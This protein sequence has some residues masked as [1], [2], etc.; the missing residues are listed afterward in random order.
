MK[1]SHK[2]AA[3]I[4]ASLGL[5]VAVSAA[6]AQPGPMGGAMGPHMQG[7]MQHSAMAGVQHGARGGT[8]HGMT[9][10]PG[11]GVMGGGAAG[12]GAGQELTTPEERSAMIEKMRNAST[13]EER[14]KIAEE[15]RAEMDKRAREKGITLPAHRG[16]HF[17]GRPQAPTTN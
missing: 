11:H 16:P 12:Q 14:L 8:Q 9:G 2:F 7:G 13:P 6:Y 5:G 3:G 4:I 10:G 15:H 17:G 1:Q